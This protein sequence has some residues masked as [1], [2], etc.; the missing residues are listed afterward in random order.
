[1][2][3]TYT[4]RTETNRKAEIFRINKSFAKSIT[5]HTACSGSI[6]HACQVIILW[7]VNVHRAAQFGV[8][9]CV[10]T[11]FRRFDTSKADYVVAQEPGELI[12]GPR[13]HTSRSSQ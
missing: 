6:A 1:V 8:F 7:I 5:Q 12:Y 3:D 13:R 11:P 10:L 2:T 9:C 4:V